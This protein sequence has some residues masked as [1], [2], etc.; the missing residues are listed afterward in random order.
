M[1]SIIVSFAARDIISI[2]RE[3]NLS[4]RFSEFFS[5]MANSS[6]LPSVK[7]KSDEHVEVFPYRILNDLSKRL[8]VAEATIMKMLAAREA[9]EN[10]KNE[11][12]HNLK[13][14]IS[15]LV[16]ENNRYHLSIS[17]CTVCTSDD[18]FSDA[19]LSDVSIKA[20]TPVST[21]LD[22]LEPTL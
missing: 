1:I 8:K 9:L 20:S 22:T 3:K 5:K 15:D 19:S 21:S 16:Y 10:E 6:L 18:G 11:E 4:R 12:V 17:Y 14:Q 2:T 7:V 13:K